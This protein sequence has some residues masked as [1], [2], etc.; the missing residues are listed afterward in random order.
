M[1]KLKIRTSG[2]DIRLAFEITYHPY[3]IGYI[4]QLFFYCALTMKREG[5]ISCS[6]LALLHPDPI[7][8][9]LIMFSSTCSLLYSLGLEE[10]TEEVG[11]QRQVLF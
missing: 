3:L 2:A 8:I 7:C 4:S 5:N 6:V 9:F 1:A 11:M 10:E